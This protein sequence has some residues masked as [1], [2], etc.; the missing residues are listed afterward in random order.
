MARRKV[1]RRRD[2]WK[3]GSGRAPSPSEAQ[4]HAEWVESSPETRYR[5]PKD[6]ERFA[7]TGRAASPSG[8]TQ[9]GMIP[10]E[11]A[12]PEMR[13]EQHSDTPQN[14]QRQNERRAAGVAGAP[15]DRL[16]RKA[17]YDVDRALASGLST[18]FY[19]KT[20]RNQVGQLAGRTGVNFQTA[21]AVTAATSPQA[22]WMA[23]DRE[24]NIERAEGEIEATIR[25]R[26]YGRIERHRPEPAWDAARDADRDY[27]FHSVLEPLARM[28]TTQ[29]VKDK[30][31]AVVDFGVAGAD[32]AIA[33]WGGMAGDEDKP[34]FGPGP[35]ETSF[36]QNFRQPGNPNN[37]VTFDRHMSDS[38]VGLEA[39]DKF[40]QSIGRYRI[41]AEAFGRAADEAGVTR[42]GGQAAA[43]TQ[44]K[45]EKGHVGGTYDETGEGLTYSE[46]QEVI[47]ANPPMFRTRGGEAVPNE[48][49][50]GAPA[51]RPR[52][53][54]DR[55]RDTRRMAL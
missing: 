26:G 38:L 5:G 9:P 1:T 29:V 31:A 41:G 22:P 14:R 4:A 20:A 36:Y 6:V 16:R 7:V 47:R 24:V 17:Q 30:A 50:T 51:H 18:D 15:I 10:D 42:E 48:V 3:P 28:E 52:S 12:L 37:R 40:R 39:G 55:S 13:L 54:E 53:V 21:A 25:D 27:R 43:W 11:T 34:V 33:R 35:K 2:A 46:R 8:Y 44:I 49:K 19:E 32:P 23:R 45:G